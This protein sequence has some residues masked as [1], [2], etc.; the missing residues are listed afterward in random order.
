MMAGILYLQVAGRLAIEFLLKSH[1][2]LKLVIPSY[3]T[4]FTAVSEDIFMLILALTHPHNLLLT[5]GGMLFIIIV[6]DYWFEI[7][8][9]VFD[10]LIIN[11]IH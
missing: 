1:R 10:L 2:E 5:T 9:I 6:S 11:F 3:M 7:F 8:G 4:L